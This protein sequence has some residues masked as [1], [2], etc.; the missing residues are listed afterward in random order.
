MCTNT[1]PVSSPTF[2][3]KMSNAD[4]AQAVHFLLPRSNNGVLISGNTS[5][6]A[7]QFHRYRSIISRIWSHRQD[8]TNAHDSVGSVSNRFQQIS[9]RKRL[10]DTDMVELISR[11][12]RMRIRPLGPGVGVDAV[13]HRIFREEASTDSAMILNRFW[14]LQL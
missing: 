8:S 7:K 10:N 9:W 11:Q 1:I 6:A 14:H 5:A 3:K 13:I 4:R 12:K 2:S